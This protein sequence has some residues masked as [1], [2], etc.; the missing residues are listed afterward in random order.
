M[1]NKGHIRVSWMKNPKDPQSKEV[2]K[3]RWAD[4]ICRNVDLIS[5]GIFRPV[6]ATGLVEMERMLDLVGS[7]YFPIF[8][9]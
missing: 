9:S 3:P 2:W 1:N 4:S 6:R 7:Q 8:P 5:S